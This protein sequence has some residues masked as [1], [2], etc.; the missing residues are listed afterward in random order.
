MEQEKCSACDV[1]PEEKEIKKG[2]M[3]LYQTDSH[4]YS[5]L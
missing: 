1:G 2:S 5:T 4:V 3:S